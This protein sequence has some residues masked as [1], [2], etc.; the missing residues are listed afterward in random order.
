M[1]ITVLLSDW[2]WLSS[3]PCCPA[4]LCSS[5]CPFSS[6]SFADV[7]SS[8]S[9]V[10]VSKLGLWANAASLVLQNHY[11]NN[12]HASFMSLIFMFVCCM[13]SLFV[14]VWSMSSL[15]V[16]ICC[17]S[18][19]FMY[20]CSVSSCCVYYSLPYLCCSSSISFRRFSSSAAS[21]CFRFSSSR[22][23]FSSCLRCFRISMS[24]SRSFSSSWICWSK[25]FC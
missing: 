13:P 10:T 17:M 14:D 21:F 9:S 8:N 25:S 20:I 23:F 22:I 5:V 16:H 7:S 4:S 1:S 6:R 12:I 18:L 15:F 3:L 24:L 11:V 2:L 19:V